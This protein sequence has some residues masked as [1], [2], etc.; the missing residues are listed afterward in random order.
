MSI[1][2]RIGN[3]PL[4]RLERITR[5]VVPAGVEVWAKLE[6]FNPGGSVKDRAA[7][8]IIHSAET[9]GRIARDTILLDSSSGNTGIAYGMICAIRGYSLTLCLPK[10]AN[11]ERKR[12]LRAY[13]VQIV[14]TDPLEGSDG[15]IRM[16]KKL[17]AEN[18][19]KYLYL[20]QY[21]NEANPRAHELGTAEE[22]WA[23]TGGRVTHW[24]AT[25][26]TS[27]SFV[28]TTRGLKKKNAAIQCISVQPDSPFHG[29]EGLKHM[30]SAIVPAIYDPAL[31]DRD[32]GAPTEPCIELRKRLAR[33]EGILA[34]VS[35]GAA[36]WGAIEVARGLES[37]VV[38]TLFPD[39]GERYISEDHLWD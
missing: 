32:L 27:G 21:G 35:A 15:A 34:G 18:P 16:A 8:N 23:Q 24:V 11:R 17:V 5:G 6:W 9:A 28:G 37:G 3:T 13:G 10:N 38:V 22:I 33:E 7:F 2:D 36:L 20:D 29:L 25:L 26:G 39:S 12:I 1:L 14:E 30:E 4:V 19:G 31:A